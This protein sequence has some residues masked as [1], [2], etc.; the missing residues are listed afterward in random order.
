MAADN[1]RVNFISLSLQGLLILSIMTFVIS[2]VMVFIAGSPWDVYAYGI[3]SVTTLLMAVGFQLI[4]RWQKLGFYIIEGIAIIASTIL[5]FVS[6]GIMAETIGGLYVP[7]AITVAVLIM[8]VLFLFI[9][10][11]GKKNGKT[12]W[13]QM[14]SG[15]DI[16]HFRHIYQLTTVLFLATIGFTAYSASSKKDYI[17]TIESETIVRINKVRP[18]SY[19]L[20]DSANITLDGIEAI[21][22]LIDSIPAELQLKYSKR[23]VAL[24]HLLV[25]GIMVSKHSPSN[26]INISKIHHGEFSDSQQQILDWYASLPKDNQELW[27]E[28]PSANNLTEFKANLLKAIEK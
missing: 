25:S 18:L 6:K 5:C 26:I 17:P 13:Q 21:E 20:L 4:I 22:P 3:I 10:R 24:K 27:I 12:C 9:L 19:E 11:N 8:L 14:S 15:A 1:H 7:I 23:V 28:C 16:R 2:Y